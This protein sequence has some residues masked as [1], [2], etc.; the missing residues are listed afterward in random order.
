LEI[1]LEMTNIDLERPKTTAAWLV[2]RLRE[3]IL[4]GK[5]PA[6]TRIRQEELAAEYSTS[7]MP[8]REALI[9]LDSEGLVHLLPNQR[10]VVTSLDGDDAIELFEIRASLEALALRRSAPR[11]NE[12]QRQ[13]AV[14]ALAAL[15]ASSPAG[16]LLTHRTF[17]LSLY[18]AAGKRL[19]RLV[20][21]QFDSA[22]RYL[23]AEATLLSTA[24]DDK[25]EHRALLDGVLSRDLRACTS[26]IKRHVR[27]AGHDIAKALNARK[28]P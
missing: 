19:L 1:Y 5:L 16:Y 17:H 26:L 4:T 13:D 10:A 28:L 27:D 24:Q 18:A 14:R 15:E 12:D 7:R 8:V 11:L 23:S 9:A 21:Q 6:G 25:D 20:V 22:D 3:A 2:T